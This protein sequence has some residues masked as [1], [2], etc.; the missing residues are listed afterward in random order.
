[1]PYPMDMHCL[2]SQCDEKEN[3]ID[4]YYSEYCRDIHALEMLN[5]DLLKALT[6]ILGCIENQDGDMESVV[7]QAISRAKC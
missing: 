4:G 2:R 7:R 3:R 6:H 5:A 1:M